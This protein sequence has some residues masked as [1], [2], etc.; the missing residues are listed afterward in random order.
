M[1]FLFGAAVVAMTVAA[2]S[3]DPSLTCGTSCPDASQPVEGGK[4]A[5]SADSKADVTQS[6]DAP[7]DAVVDSPIV[8]TGSPPTDGPC[9]TT[10]PTGSTCTGGFCQVPQGTACSAAVATAGG[11]GDFDGTVCGGTQPTITTTCTNPITASASFL[12]FTSGGDPWNVTLKAVNGPLQ[13]EVMSD[14]STGTSCTSL[15]AGA[16]TTILVGPSTIIA[17]VDVNTSCTTWQITYQSK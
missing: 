3:V 7:I 10:C 2:C 13:F 1:R 8:D 11:S 12:R 16:S 5:T 4:D 15:A 14:C 6:S 9:T 17:I